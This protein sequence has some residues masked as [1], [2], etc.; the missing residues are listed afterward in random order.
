MKT[1]GGSLQRISINQLRGIDRISHGTF[2]SF[3][4]CLG[5][6]I[7]YTVVYTWVSYNNLEVENTKEIFLSYCSWYYKAKNMLT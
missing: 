3:G 5:Y 6:S 1:K 4:I 2:L 7:S